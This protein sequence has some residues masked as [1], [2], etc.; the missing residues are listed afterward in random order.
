MVVAARQ[1]VMTVL[2]LLYWPVLFVLAHIPIPK[3]V[4]RAQVSDKSLHFLAHLLLVLL[5][6]FAVRPQTKVRWR[7]AALWWA[8][9]V[10]VWYGAF[11]ELLQ[12]CVGG[13]SCDFGDFLGD[14]AGS[15]TGLVLFAIFTFWPALLVVTGTAVFLLTNLARV[16]PAELIP[17]ASTLF[18]F[19]GYGVF[20]LVW[21]RCLHLLG[22]RTRVGLKW[23]AAALSLPAAL[24]I[25]VKL[26]S[27]V[28]EKSF[29]P[30]SVVIAAAGIVVAVTSALLFA[31]L[32][33]RLWGRYSP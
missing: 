23:V 24:L 9:F 32:R 15:V 11:D 31:S 12:S 14:L 2:L 10:A 28:L 17:R 25:T 21:I 19:L 13:R 5:L 1:R 8:L 18:Y 33:H 3:L 26:F 7:D 27:L 4:Y 6:W 16:N 30:R 20:A 22:R 29:A